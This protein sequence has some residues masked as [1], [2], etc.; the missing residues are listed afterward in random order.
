MNPTAMNTKLQ[1]PNQF[2]IGP[3]HPDLPGNWQKVDISPKLRITARQGLNVCHTTRGGL[4]LLLIGFIIDPLNPQASD[5]DLIE[6]LMD[7]LN[8]ERD[9]YKRC[10]ALGGRWILIYSGNHGHRLVGDAIGLRQ[11]FYTDRQFCDELWLASQPRLLADLKGFRIDDKAAE[12]IDSY[13]FRSYTEFRWPGS[14]SPYTEVRHLLPNHYLD[15]TSGQ[16]HRFWPDAPIPTV[17]MEEAAEKVSRMLK[18]FMMG[19][20]ERFDLAVSLTAGLDSRVVF[21]ATKEICDQI[22][23]LTVRQIDKPDQHADVVTAG[24]I[25]SMVGQPHDVIKSSLIVDDD[26]VQS[27]KNNTALPHYIYVCDAQAI[28]RRYQRKKVVATGSV[29]EIGR[30]SFRAQLGKPESEEITPDDLAK[31]QKME[32]QPYAVNAFRDW[33]TDLGNPYNIPLLDIFEWEQGHG[34]WLAMTQL[35]FDIAWQDLYAPFNCRDLLVTL[36]GVDAKFRCKPNF[37][38]YRRIIQI[39]WP[40]LLDVPINPHEKASPNL[41]RQ[42][43]SK[44]PY[45]VKKFYKQTLK[46]GKS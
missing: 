28:L 1:Y 34:N 27:F 15:L 24:Q 35:E 21:S 5:Q 20:A 16:C 17:A 7:L 26:F 31:L 4:D 9:F 30:L 18:G 46:G 40:E 45:P 29:S 41:F 37:E 42:I 3:S 10:S 43:K 12:L 25:L 33:L 6:E 23:V 36:L 11:V 19:A 38:L 32:K 22:S 14:G 44:V 39:L 8:D 2:I 13:T